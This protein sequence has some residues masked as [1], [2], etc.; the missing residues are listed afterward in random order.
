M[1]IRRRQVWR[2]IYL[3]LC[4]ILCRTIRG[5]RFWSASPVNDSRARLSHT[6][7][8]RS[9]N[10]SERIALS[11][12]R[13]AAKCKPRGQIGWLFARHCQVYQ[14]LMRG[15]AR[16]PSI[17]LQPFARLSL[18]PISRRKSQRLNSELHKRPISLLTRRYH[19]IR[20]AVSVSVPNIVWHISK[21][22]PGLIIVGV[23]YKYRF[24]ISLVK[25]L[26]ST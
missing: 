26:K 23:S 16:Y 22:D 24:S 20:S 4:P 6:A 8:S 3:D 5:F 17:C 18:G 1:L 9:R 2:T 15:E 14:M 25:N 19:S 12:R 13:Q 11:I 10:A 7:D 21:M